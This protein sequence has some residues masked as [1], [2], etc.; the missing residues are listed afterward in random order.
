MG[1]VVGSKR[2]GRKGQVSTNQMSNNEVADQPELPE[3]N[4]GSTPATT[5]K[6]KRQLNE[7]ELEARRKGGR[8]RGEQLRGTSDVARKAG[9]VRGEQLKRDKAHQ[10]MAGKKANAK[11]TPEERAERGRKNLAIALKNYPDMRE[12]AGESSAK[13]HLAEKER[14]RLEREQRAR[15]EAERRRLAGEPE[16]APPAPK[17]PRKRGKSKW[18][19]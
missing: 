16:P 13:R 14:K 3:E 2:K 5:P 10:S 18:E 4:T 15:V 6:P 12:R 11:R 8:A 17:K 7:A 19:R 9:L 1:A